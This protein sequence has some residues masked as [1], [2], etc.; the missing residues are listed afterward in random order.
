MGVFMGD[1]QGERFKTIADRFLDEIS[2]EIVRQRVPIRQD[3]PRG[4]PATEFAATALLR[5]S[6]ARSGDDPTIAV[7]SLCH[8]LGMV[9]ANQ[10]V[11]M[12]D[13]YLAQIAGQIEA[14]ALEIE[15]D[16]RARRTAT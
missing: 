10:D 7:D 2:A 4:R 1:G 13:Q 14:D 11:A 15:T 9:L 12:W 6:V 16:R 5:A 8:A 3:A